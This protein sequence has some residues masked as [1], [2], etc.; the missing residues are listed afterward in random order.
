MPHDVKRSALEDARRDALQAQTVGAAL[1][2][3]AGNPVAH[4]VHEEPRTPGEEDLPMMRNV[5]VTMLT[6]GTLAL[7]CSTTE[8]KPPA[9]KSAQGARSGSK[10]GA[11]ST[12]AP[13][14][15]GSGSTSASPPASAAPEESLADKERWAGQ[16]YYMKRDGN[17]VQLA[18]EACGFEAGKGM[19]YAWDK[20]S[21][22]IQSDDWKSHSPNGYCGSAFSDIAYM[23]R[24]TEGAKGA[25][26]A[27]IKRV[28][29]RLGGKGN[30]GVT[31]ANGTLTYAIDWDQ[32]NA[33]DML[34]TRVK[35][36]L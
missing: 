13:P 30:F 29:C 26:Q 33:D 31:L 24:N 34:T 28:V 8:A 4:R 23:C 1:A 6:I 19:T 25:V 3:R 36:L 11:A 35:Q 16:D 22:K 27:K 21:F 32:A 9:K 14:S 12:P 7:V 10:A 15:T 5:V 17:D 20:P 2:I 18:N